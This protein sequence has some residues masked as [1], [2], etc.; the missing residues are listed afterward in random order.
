ML[1]RLL[2]TLRAEIILASICAISGDAAAMDMTK[3]MAT[4]VATTEGEVSSPI[5]D[6]A[7]PCASALT[8]I[9]RELADGVL[10]AVLL[11]DMPGVWCVVCRVQRE[12]AKCPKSSGVVVAKGRRLR[13]EFERNLMELFELS[14]ATEQLLASNS[15][16]K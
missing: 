8:S 2:F 9:F 4:T 7:A 15:R 16:P 10:F 11:C 6:S 12:M 5:A 14:L 1:R 3:T 13:C